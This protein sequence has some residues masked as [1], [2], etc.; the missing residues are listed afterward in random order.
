MQIVLDWFGW[1][2]SHAFRTLNECERNKTH[3]H[4]YILN[5]LIAKYL[6]ERMSNNLTN[7][8][9]VCHHINFWEI[10]IQRWSHVANFSEVLTNAGNPYSVPNIH[11]TIPGNHLIGAMPIWATSWSAEG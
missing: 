3:W 4:F 8:N 10:I 2:D 1:K 6:H 11:C 5:L 9:F 7:I